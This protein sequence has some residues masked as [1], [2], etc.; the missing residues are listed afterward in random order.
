MYKRNLCMKAKSGFYICC[1]CCCSLQTDTSYFFLSNWDAFYFY[2]LSNCL[3]QDF[4][5]YVKQKCQ[6]WALDLGGEVVSSLPPPLEMNSQAHNQLIFS[7]FANNIQWKRIKSLQQ[8]VLGKLDVHMQNNEI[9]PL[10]HT[11]YQKNPQIIKVK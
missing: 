9:E 11:I 6:G 1:C 4:Q 2:L 10:S 7:K 8:I 5:Y 3:D